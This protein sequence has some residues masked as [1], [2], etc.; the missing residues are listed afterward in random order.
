MVYQTGLVNMTR[1]QLV[2]MAIC[3]GSLTWFGGKPD[4]HRSRSG[5][6]AVIAFLAFNVESRLERGMNRQNLKFTN[7][8]SH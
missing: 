2:R 1:L 4:Q 6:H 7:L 5:A 3:N 8:N